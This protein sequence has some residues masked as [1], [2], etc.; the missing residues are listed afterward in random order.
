MTD[1]AHLFS[2]TTRCAL[3]LVCLCQCCCSA[4]PSL[5]DR[6]VKFI[7]DFNRRYENGTHEFERR[8]EIFKM[9]L[10]RIEKLNTPYRE[11]DSAVFGINKFSDLSQEEFAAQYLDDLRPVKLSGDTAL[12]FQSE[13]PSGRK[14]I[15]PSLLP[16]KIDWRAR[17]KISPI[18]NQGRCGACWAFAAAE[19]VES[20]FA[21][22]HNISAPQ[23][24]VQQLIDCSDKN[25]GCSGGDICIALD[26]IK[27]TGITF[28]KNYPLTDNDGTCHTLRPAEEVINIT[29]YTCNKYVGTEDEILHILATTGPVSAAV[30]ASTWNNYVGGIIKFHCLNDINHAVDIVG[31]DLTGPVPYYIVRNS[32]GTDFG[33]DGYM[34]IKVGSNLCGIAEEVSEVH[35]W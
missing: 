27:M 35:L 26:Y 9:N 33:M 7:D 12:R 29:S 18:K 15:A 5:L 19:V 3:V 28:Q 14:G 24:A 17:G 10:E 32:W 31:Y 2:N 13:K 6:F 8:F 22:K 23:L 34:Y 25:Y 16:K 30:D 1:M 11:G 21:I 4:K 20:A